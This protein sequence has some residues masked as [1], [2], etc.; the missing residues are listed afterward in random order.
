MQKLRCYISILFAAWILSSCKK[1]GCNVVPNVTFHTT[2]S[3]ATAAGAF[4]PNGSAY[5]NGGVR[6]L[7]IC[8]VTSSAG[9]YNFMA[10]DRCSPVNPEQRNTVVIVN[11][12]YAEDPAS[13]AKWLLK[14]G[15]PLAIAECSLKPYYVS[16]FGGSYT[17]SN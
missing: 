7:I 16:S 9:N 2:F 6:G 11:A 14:D 12:I 5:V 13:G 4:S 1:G 15:S 3:Q 10:Y 17:V 8:N